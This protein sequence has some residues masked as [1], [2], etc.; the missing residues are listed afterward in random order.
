MCENTV[1]LQR[2]PL[3]EPCE[4]ISL[5]VLNTITLASTSKDEAVSLAWWCNHNHPKPFLTH[6]RKQACIS[7]PQKTSVISVNLLVWG[8]VLHHGHLETLSPLQLGPLPQGGKPLHTLLPGRQGRAG[9]TLED[10]E[11][12]REKKRERAK[13]VVKV[14]LWQIWIYYSFGCKLGFT[15]KNNDVV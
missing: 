12:G 5:T 10:G 3:N 15:I 14:W 8:G 9:L 2:C 7:S 4:T 6:T 11:R 1:C 13:R